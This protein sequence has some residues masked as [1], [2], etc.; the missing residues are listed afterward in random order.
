MFS[1][2][3]QKICDLGTYHNKVAELQVASQAGSFGSNTL[4]QTTITLRGD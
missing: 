4:H 2:Q 3:T 1:L